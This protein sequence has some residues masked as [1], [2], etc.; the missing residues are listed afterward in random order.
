MCVLTRRWVS[1]KQKILDRRRASGFTRLYDVRETR[2][3]VE[4]KR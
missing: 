3:A 2:S 4:R 1:R